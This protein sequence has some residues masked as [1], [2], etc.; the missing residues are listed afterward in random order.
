[1]G[2]VGQMEVYAAG[3]EIQSL[4]EQPSVARNNSNSKDWC[5]KIGID[6]VENS[7]LFIFTL[8]RLH[9]TFEAHF[10]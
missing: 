9:F 6:V 10:T 2:V 1:M 4:V 5:Y 7:S 8:K 3:E